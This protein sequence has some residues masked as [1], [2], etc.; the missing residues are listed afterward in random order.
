VDKPADSEQSLGLQKE[1]Y[2]PFGS[3]SEYYL[4]AWLAE[5]NL[6]G[7]NVWG[8]NKWGIATMLRR[9]EEETGIPCNPHTKTSERGSPWKWCRSIRGQ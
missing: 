1:G 7:G 8:M 4:K 6:N 5:F 3:L 9:L 2:A